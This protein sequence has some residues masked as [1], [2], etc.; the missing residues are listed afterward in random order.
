MTKS[1]TPDAH[2]GAFSESTKASSNDVE[3]S[4]PI[5]ADDELANLKLLQQTVRMV[6]RAN[7]LR[8]SIKTPEENM[9]GSARSVRNTCLAEAE[10][11]VYNEA[12]D[13]IDKQA[14]EIYIKLANTALQSVMATDLHDLELGKPE[15]IGFD[16]FS[17]HVS[18]KDSKDLRRSVMRAQKWRPKHTDLLIKLPGGETFSEKQ[19]RMAAESISQNPLIHLP[20]RFI[21]E[22]Y[23]EPQNTCTGLA[24]FWSFIGKEYEGYPKRILMS[25]ELNSAFVYNPGKYKESLRAGNPDEATYRHNLSNKIISLEKIRDRLAEK[26][27]LLNNARGIVTGT[28]AIDDENPESL[29]RA[30]TKLGKAYEIIVAEVD[31]VGEARGWDEERMDRMRSRL[32]RALVEGESENGEP[33]PISEVWLEAIVKVGQHLKNQHDVFVLDIAQLNTSKRCK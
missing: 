2:S 18:E 3:L 24:D 5:G 29:H 12:A 33:I 27:N 13:I 26:S 9:S 32:E 6:S 31:V 17:S 25:S 4:V 8:A 14:K 28:E 30:T 23:T 7:N 21:E 22:R 11:L 19:N 16:K 1:N 15:I 10:G 20:A